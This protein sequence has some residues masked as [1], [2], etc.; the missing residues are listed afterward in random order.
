[1]FRS[2]EGQRE[3]NQPDLVL[4]LR[5]TAFSIKKARDQLVPCLHNRISRI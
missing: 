3:P 4:L 5:S 1:M 2:A